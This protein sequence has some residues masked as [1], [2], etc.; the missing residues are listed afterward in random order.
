MSEKQESD[1]AFRVLIPKLKGQ[2]NY[3]SWRPQIK[4]IIVT[5]RLWETVS[6]EGEP[7]PLEPSAH[8]S[9]C[10]FFS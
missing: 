5:N 7:P 9:E 2:K 3:H 10:Q 6:G 8:L 4:A 1:S